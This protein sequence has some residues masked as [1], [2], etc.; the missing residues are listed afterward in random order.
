ML[1][2]YISTFKK[3][4]NSWKSKFRLSKCVKMVDFAL[5][6]SSKLISRKIWAIGKS[7]NCQIC[8][9]I[10]STFFL[11]SYF[12]TCCLIFIYRLPEFI[13]RHHT[14]TALLLLPKLVFHTVGTF[15]KHMVNFNCYFRDWGHT[16]FPI[17]L[18]IP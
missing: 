6:E 11:P 16:T 3:C 9:K 17:D 5:L 14:Y 2:L 12:W 15:L 8:V 10:L 4:K 1:I 18:C 13:L 7:S